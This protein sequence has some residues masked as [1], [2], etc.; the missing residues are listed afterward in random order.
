[1][2]EADSPIETSQRAS[3]INQIRNRILDAGL[4]VYT[5]ILVPSVAI[6][7]YRVVD[8]GWQPIF[9]VHILALFLM[10]LVTLLR[11]HLSFQTKAGFLIVL[12]GVLG[13]TALTAWGLIGLG[14]LAS[15]I[16]CLF[17]V[18]LFGSRAGMWVLGFSVV[19]IAVIGT[20]VTNG[21]LTFNFDH[22]VFATA[23][24]SWIMAIMILS[25]FLGTLIAGFGR[26]HAALIDSIENLDQKVLERK[27][28]EKAV[29][30]SEA[31]FRTLVENAPEAVV[32]LNAKTGRFEDANK[33]AV[34]LF[35]LERDELL[36]LGAVDVSPPMQPNGRP[37]DEFA[38]EQIEKV[39][40]GEVPVF[41]WTHRNASGDDFPCEVRLVMLP[42]TD[43]TLV[44]GSITDITARK[45][46]EEVLQR[47]HEEL[48]TLVEQRTRALS[49]SENRFRSLF[50]GT[51]VAVVLRDPNTLRCVDC[52][53]AAVKMFGF[54]DRD[55]LIGTLHSDVLAPGSYDTV[56]AGQPTGKAMKEGI[57]PF[58]WR[59]RKRDGT[60]FPADVV[61]TAIEMDGETILQSVIMDMTER[62]QAE[63]AL[64]AINRAKTS[65]LSSMSHELR[66]PLNA[67]IG[68]SDLLGGQHL[69][70][71]NEKQLSYVKQVSSG[72][73][74]L[75]ALINDIL[76]MAKIDAGV[77]QAELGEVDPAEM[78]E[79]VASMMKAQFKEKQLELTVEVDSSVRQ[80]RADERKFKQILL[81]LLSNAI[82][83]TPE[84]GRVQIRTALVNS[85]WYR[86]EV[87]D[88]G[89]G[90]DPGEQ[91]KIFS[92]FY[93]ADQIRDEALGGI[94][95]GLALTRRLV[96]L[97]GGEIGVESEV[98][99]GS[100]FWFTLP[101]KGPVVTEQVGEKLNEAGK[102]ASGR[103]I[104]VAEDDEVNLNLI[105]DLLSIHGYD[106]VVAK[107]GQEAVD[108][109]QR[110][111]PNLILMDVK[112][113][114][115]GGLEATEQIRAMP[116]FSDLPIIAL[117]ASV[118]DADQMQ[119]VA[120]GCTAFLPKPLDSTLLFET[121]EKYLK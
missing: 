112:M 30:E 38:R 1:M 90:I 67:I 105:L 121:I 104:L 69:G 5:A 57:H 7:V 76:D 24:S 33:N 25:M 74:H 19:A 118:G 21:W 41:E 94:G 106:V 12:W 10:I 50:E 79:A 61:L 65:F 13:L 23:P 87:T 85:S 63:E 9:F 45:Q 96:E 111:Q 51:K 82:K 40:R 15:V 11:H 59:Y 35:G 108:L 34:R 86:V 62:E 71:L 58:R 48:E 120:A 8:L 22:N 6:S 115:M 60:E 68:S 88:T 4:L 14:L 101:Y 107:N 64:K 117:T 114:V 46:A 89:L 16:S 56:A 20:A 83:Y 3:T 47:S 97:H 28:A 77:M 53:Q 119:Q 84:R 66:T 98:G 110:H 43:G 93:Q 80:I 109:T 55:Q 95:L 102:M 72:G 27:E 116:E 54:S 18:L 75:L 49:R 113:P 44:R 99:K 42:G 73:K 36:K 29:I 100:T 39:T 52:N 31:R 17:T 92:E 26:F 78:V 103:R 91:K 81:N 37:T 2:T 70:P 32:V